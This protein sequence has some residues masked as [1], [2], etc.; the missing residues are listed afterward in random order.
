[1]GINLSENI[2]IADASVNIH[3]VYLAIGNLF[4]RN[5]VLGSAY[6]CDKNK[7][8]A[9]VNFSVETCIYGNNMANIVTLKLSNKK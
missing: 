1:V 7:A 4:M 5:S 3:A 9:F 8:S 2:A 6:C